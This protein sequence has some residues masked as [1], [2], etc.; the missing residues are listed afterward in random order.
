[1]SF[2]SKPEETFD[3]LLHPMNLDRDEDLV[4]LGRDFM[5]QFRITKFD[6]DQKK[7]NLGP[8]LIWEITKEVGEQR[9][10]LKV[11]IGKQ[12]KDALGKLDK[13]LE[14]FQT[15]FPESPKGPRACSM[16][17][18]VIETTTDQVVKDK[19][20]PIAKKWENEI[21]SQIEEMAKY[22]I[23][24]ESSSPYNQNIILADKKEGRGKRFCVDFRSLNKKTIKDSYPL[25][26]V[27]ELFCATFGSRLFSQLDLASG[28]WTV[29]IREEDQEKTAFSVPNGKW[30]FVRMPYGLVNAQATLQRIM[31]KIL[32]RARE[33]GVD[34]GLEVYVD[35]ILV[36]S[37]DLDSH[38]EI[39]E[40]IFEILDQQNFSLREDKC[41]FLFQ[42]MEFLGFVINGREVKMSPS[43]T[44]KVNQF[45]I[46]G[47]R[48]AVQRFLGL[49]NFNRQFIKDYAEVTAP[50]AKLTSDKVE[51]QWGDDQAKAFARIKEMLVTA[52]ALQMPDWNRPFEMETDAS[53][54]AVG[55]ILFQRDVT[56]A[57]RTIAYHSKSLSGC[58]KRWSATDKEFYAIISAS[59]KWPTFCAQ[60]ITFHTD[61]KPLTYL[62]GNSKVKG[63]HARW[64]L[65]LENFEYEIA[66]I[67]G[68]ENKAAD[69]LSRE[70]MPELEEEPDS[71][72][73]MYS[74]ELTA[75][76]LVTVEEIRKQQKEDKETCEA[77]KQLEEMGCVTTGRFSKLNN[78][79][80]DDSLFKKGKRIVVPK[81]LQKKIAV[82]YHSQSHPGAENTLLLL[83][84]RFY[85]QGMDKMVESL[86]KECRTC[87]KCKNVRQ[88]KAKMVLQDYSEMQ[89]QDRIAV[90]IGAMPPSPS[91]NVCFL[92]IVDVATK[93]HA[94]VSCK[95][96]HAE[97]LIRAL[98]AKWFSVF[99][100]P[101]ELISDQGRNFVG[102]DFQ[103]MC[104]TLGIKKRKSSP[105]HPEGN[106]H[107]ERTI[108]TIK[109]IVR[110]MCEARKVP[111]TLWDTVIDEAV[112]YSNSY[113]NKS[114]D[115]SPFECLFGTNPNLPIDNCVGI[116]DLGE[117]R[118]PLLIQENAKLN[119]ID[120]AKNYKVQ[121]DKRAHETSFEVGQEVLIKRNFG[122]YPKLSVKWNEGPYKI[123][124]KVGPVNFA[125]ENAKGVSKILHH[126]NLKPA[127]VNILQSE[128][129]PTYGVVWQQ[130][131]GAELSDEG[132]AQQDREVAP[133]R[134]GSWPVVSGPE[135]DRGTFSQRVF[136]QGES[137]CTGIQ[138]PGVVKTRSGRV[139]KPVVGSRL[140]ID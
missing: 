101:K 76:D 56:G 123:I 91:G 57:K 98:W 38:L 79:L 31:D 6:W 111:V 65:E 60:G 124:K 45:P 52:P 122:K 82:A 46:P 102:K 33:K 135:I 27:Q 64:L 103:R 132:A 5:K 71:P 121:H 97:T 131:L 100:V 74:L 22:G 32:D 13:L 25:P 72:F 48:K 44:H 114:A 139:S 19:I 70:L 58:E 126:N 113:R 30:E 80:V 59:R 67:P 34:R 134:A 118:D 36:H 40:I 116:T 54:I 108:G 21:R 55:A 77:V 90:D 2:K 130:P 37:T 120:A 89:P 26:N 15:L 66:Y 106:S 39:L 93:F 117:K 4:I 50:L 138:T 41:E 99:G 20:W 127:G 104:D 110:A 112:L 94:T 87:L 63:K 47:N 69:Y 53:D 133:E 61:H 23:I 9:K 11:K 125:V 17:H 140:Y 42:E 109:S 107:V 68:K 7:V 49:T 51:F 84:C 12:G 137:D 73:E 10:D 78:L 8:H 1:M 35:N 29:P 16:G 24:K 62:K 92:A 75:R 119:R 95:D 28:Y 129:G 3:H 105:F 86:V 83:K 88:P 85:W 96:Q 128:S 43:N 14:K 115:F 18:H 81:A 136:Q